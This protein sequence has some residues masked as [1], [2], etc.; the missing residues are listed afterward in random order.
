MWVL[1]P[2]Q[3]LMLLSTMH[4]VIE[5][6]A[7]VAA[8]SPLLLTALGVPS[9]KQSQTTCMHMF[10]SVRGLVKVLCVL[11]VCWWCAGPRYPAAL[12]TGGT[13]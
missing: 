1:G 10:V 6:A 4:A 2:Q 8:N 12:H 11:I 3:I 9:R 5:A 7:A 13:G